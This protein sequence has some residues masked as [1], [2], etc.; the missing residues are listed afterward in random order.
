MSYFMLFWIYVCRAVNENF[1]P[2]TCPVL[3]S[4]VPSV[5]MCTLMSLNL[6]NSLVKLY[7]CG[8]FIPLCSCKHK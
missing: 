7:F 6:F 5:M 4:Y 2:V 1:P 3:P 8:N